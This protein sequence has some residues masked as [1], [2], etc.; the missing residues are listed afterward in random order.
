M[1]KTINLFTVAV[2]FLISTTTMAQLLSNTTFTTPSPGWYQIGKWETG[3]RGSERVA[4]SLSGGSHAPQ[5]LIIDVFKNWSSAFTV[6]CKGS[7]NTSLQQVRITK[8]ATYYYLEVYFNI[9]I[10]NNGNIHRY[11]LAGKSSGLSTNSGV[12]PPGI[13]NE[14]FYE[15]ET[16]ANNSFLGGNI[17]TNSK[18]G[19]GTLSPTEKLE[20]NGN[21]KLGYNPTL[22][23]DSNSLSLVSKTDAISVVT[24]KGTNSYNPRL[25]IWNKGN[26][27]KTTYI[28]GDGLFYHKGNVGIGT[29]NTQSFKLAVNGDM[30]ATKVKVALQENWSDFVFYDNYKLPTLKEVENHIQEKGHLKNIPSAIEVEKNG[31]FLGEMDAKLLQ[32]IEELTL[33]TIQQEKALNSQREEIELLKEQKS[34]IEKLEEENKILKSLI[35]RLNKLEAQIKK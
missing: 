5:E 4:V 21:L 20:V 24:I 29:S 15:I 1:K 12:L 25:D 27:E 22:T 35:E 18:I 32:K 19:I 6:D 28:Q 26:T 2:C 17:V 33:Y 30:V 16:P 34:K 3:Q 11:A 13:D 9:A 23:W 14:I 10:L 31:F 8:D 7:R